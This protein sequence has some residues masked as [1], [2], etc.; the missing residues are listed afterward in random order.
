MYNRTKIVLLFLWLLSLSLSAEAQD[1]YTKQGDEAFN[2][3]QYVSAI[4]FYKKAISETKNQPEREQ[5]NYKLAESYTKTA[6]WKNAVQQLKKLDKS[7]FLDKNPDGT[8]LFATALQQMGNDSAAIRYYDRYLILKPKD[9]AINSR[10]S[11]LSGLSKPGQPSAYKIANES[12]LNS[13]KDDFCPVPSK[14]DGSEIVFT[15]NRKGVTGKETDQWTASY[16]TDLFVARSKPGGGFITPELLDKQNKVNTN[17]NEGTPVFNSDY[18]QI[19]CTRCEQKPERKSGTM[20]CYIISADKIGK[21]WS[22]PE[23]AYADPEGNTG[24]PALSSDGLSLVFSA[25][26]AKG[27]GGKDLWI[28]VREA[29]DKKFGPGV[30]LGTSINTAGDEMFPFFRNDSSL[31]FASNGHGGYGGLDIYVGHKLTDGSWG[32]PE[33]IGQPLNSGSDDFGLVFI[34]GKDEGYFSSNRIGGKG[35]DDIY[36]FTAVHIPFQLSGTVRDAITAIHLTDAQV[37]LLYAGDTTILTTDKEGRYQFSGEKLSNGLTGSVTTTKSD[38]LSQSQSLLVKTES[39]PLMILDFSLTPI[40]ARAV[41]LPEI[42]YDLDSWEL[43]PRYQDSLAPLVRLLA[44]NPRIKI[45]LSSHTDSRADDRYNEELSQK[46]AQGVVNYLIKCGIDKN[47]LKARGYGERKPRVIENEL[48]KGDLRIPA[49]TI[50]NENYIS[51]L[52]NDIEREQVHQL[53]RRTE[54]IIL[55]DK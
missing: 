39:N 26:N 38:Y 30:N 42:L 11:L 1:K 7:H 41:I 21:E 18:S 14:S 33:N 16:F 17:A 54:F 28:T 40:P 9:R 50:L 19:Y 43:L 55:T 44:E 32:N 15:S 8:L 13:A 52:T 5:L 2:H 4:G 47:R 53:N 20:W 49:G 6:D 51:G 48:S 36:S 34:P 23:V 37:I 25:S 27:V 12:S 3:H 31:Y 10:R 29:K 45:E 35:G 24:H 46:R 22:D